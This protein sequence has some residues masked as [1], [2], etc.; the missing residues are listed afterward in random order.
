MADRGMT[1]AV[2]TEIA[3][4]QN[5]PFHLVDI[6]FTTGTVYFT[7]SNRDIDWNY[8]TYTAAGDFLTFS[9]I[10]EQNAMTVG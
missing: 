2:L 6:Q 1:A 5:K 7:D 3:E 9:D 8:R 10:T 4:S